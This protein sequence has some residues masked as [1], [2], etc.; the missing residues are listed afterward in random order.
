MCVVTKVLNN[1]K[2]QE[3]HVHALTMK[4]IVGK[5]NKSLLICGTHKWVVGQRIKVICYTTED[6][7]PTGLWVYRYVVAA[8]LL[9]VLYE[10][11]EVWEVT[12]NPFR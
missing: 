7:Q 8:N 3:L 12:L 10:D 6:E 9:S 11:D 2:E 4:T 5:C 1:E